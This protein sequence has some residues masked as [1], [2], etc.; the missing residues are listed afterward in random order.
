LGC[1]FGSI[2]ELERWM[3]H[4]EFGSPLFIM[5]M[6]LVYEFDIKVLKLINIVAYRISNI[7]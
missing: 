6:L 3:W 7:E 2:E 1:K 4:S 5:G